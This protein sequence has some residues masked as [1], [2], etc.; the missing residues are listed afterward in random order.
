[1]SS[2]NVAFGRVIVNLRKARNQSQ[3][4]FAWSIESDRNYIKIREYKG[5]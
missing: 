2:I 4:E 3:E 5:L 1:M